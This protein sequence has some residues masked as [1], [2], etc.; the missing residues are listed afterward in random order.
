MNSKVAILGGG[1]AG[2]MAAIK[3]SQNGADVVLIEKNKSLGKKILL[4]GNGRCNI[5]H[6]GLTPAQFCQAYG[7]NGSF[8]I[9]AIAGFG[10]G[11]MIKFLNVLG[12]KTYSQDDGRVFPESDD[13]Q[14]V[15]KV[16]KKELI[17]NKVTILTDSVIKEIKK[18]KNKISSIVLENGEIIKADNFI[19]TTGGKSYP[20]A[21]STGDGLLW[22]KDLGH[23]I[24]DPNPS[25]VP[26]KTKEDWPAKLQGIGFDDVEITLLDN[27]KRIARQRGE[28][29]FTH[30]GISGPAVLNISREV[31]EILPQHNA[32]I[33]ID[34]Y[35]NDS[36]DKILQSIQR[37]FSDNGKRSAKNILAN[38]MPER[39]AQAIFENIN[40]DIYQKPEGLSH[41]CLHNLVKFLKGAPLTVTETLG[42]EGAMATNG[43]V[44]LK[45]I[46]SKTMKSKIITNLFFA[47][48]VM[49]LSGWTGGY[50]LQMCWTTGYV[51]GI[52]ASK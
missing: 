5:T 37:D 34:F 45:E 52:E 19:L 46:D 50:N 7:K 6:T 51:A 43:G 22:A 49:D 27:G 16:L 26:L 23:K 47:G 44:D 39:F 21:G 48:E 13:A 30:F 28:V 12:L 33:I 1:P 11:Q 8:L 3:A 40:C 25:L 24:I 41:E 15:L 2:I 36:F 38:V 35:P 14:D 31:A 10:P 20:T 32:Q 42:F 17:K 29:V 18:T 4:S 9:S